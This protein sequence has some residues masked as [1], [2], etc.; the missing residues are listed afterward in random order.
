MKKLCGTA[1]TASLLQCRQEIDTVYRQMLELVSL[2]K[3]GE[4]ITMTISIGCNPD[5]MSYLIDESW[6]TEKVVRCNNEK[7]D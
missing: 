4:S 1:Y 6:E 7:T 5:D 2:L 3:G